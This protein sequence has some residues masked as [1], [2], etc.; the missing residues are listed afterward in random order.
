MEDCQRGALPMEKAWK[1]LED[2]GRYW[3]I[4]ESCYHGS[5]LDID[6]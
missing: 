2:N 6:E 1:S 5:C 4:L 3:K